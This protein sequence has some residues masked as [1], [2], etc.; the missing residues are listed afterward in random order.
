MKSRNE[1]FTQN[2]QNIYKLLLIL[3]LTLLREIIL[4]LQLFINPVSSY[5]V[6]YLQL[7]LDTLNVH[8]IYLNSSIYPTVGPQYSNDPL[9]FLGAELKLISPN[10]N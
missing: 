1:L 6:K 4:Y 2:A 3:S 10:L 9:L 8:I 7:G 5:L